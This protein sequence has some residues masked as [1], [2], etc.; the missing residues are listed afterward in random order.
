MLNTQYYLYKIQN[1]Q[2][3][4]KKKVFPSFD[5]PDYLMIYCTTAV[6]MGQFPSLLH[7]ELHM[8]FQPGPFWKFLI[9]KLSAMNGHKD[10]QEKKA[11]NLTWRWKLP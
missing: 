11:K 10:N 5:I 9:F 1:V 3:K 7:S 2:S 4:E 6:N 8:T